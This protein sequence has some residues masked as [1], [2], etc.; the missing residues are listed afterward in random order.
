MLSVTL[1]VVQVIVGLKDETEI[2]VLFTSS[3]SIADEV[4]CIQGHDHE[5]YG[6]TSDD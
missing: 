2:Y 1:T 5:H 6:F 4:Y 3:F